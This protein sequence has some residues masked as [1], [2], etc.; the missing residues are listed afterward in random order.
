MP[1]AGPLAN[2]EYNA[3]ASSERPPSH[4]VCALSCIQTP[5]SLQSSRL[6]VSWRCLVSLEGMAGF[7]FSGCR[8]SPPDRRQRF[9]LVKGTFRFEVQAAEP[10][11]LRTALTQ[12]ITSK[13]LH[14]KRKQVGIADR[15]KNGSSRPVLTVPLLLR[16][17][18][19]DADGGV[20]NGRGH[21][22]LR[23]AWFLS[24]NRVRRDERKGVRMQK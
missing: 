11:S 14:V 3:A 8:D 6:R 19:Q 15:T 13:R 10:W 12:R 21:L 2:S 4:R 18:H 7:P 22:A 20:K 1:R 5:A 9:L 24:L 16:T 17:N 23:I